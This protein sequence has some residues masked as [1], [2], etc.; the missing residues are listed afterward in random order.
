MQRAVVSVVALLWALASSPHEPV[1]GLWRMN[2]G[3]ALIQISPDGDRLSMLY[4][5]GPD[6]SI[7]PGTPIGYLVAGAEAGVY[8]CHATVDPRGRQSLQ[9]GAAFVVRLKGDNADELEFDA[10]R[11]RPKLTVRVRMPWLFNVNVSRPDSPR[12]LDGGRRADSPPPFVVL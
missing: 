3:G 9:A 11:D 2:G 8:D 12:G 1:E 10:Y 7:P 4:L 6:L 5:D